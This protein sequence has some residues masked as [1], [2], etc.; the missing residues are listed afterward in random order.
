MASQTSTTT[1][2]T[3]QHSRQYSLTSDMEDKG[4]RKREVCHTNN[5]GKANLTGI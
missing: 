5:T 1:T 4:E 3:R 2:T